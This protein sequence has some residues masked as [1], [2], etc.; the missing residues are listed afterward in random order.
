MMRPKTSHLADSKGRQQPEMTP[1]KKLLIVMAALA[2]L[3]V[4][5]QDEGTVLKSSTTTVGYAS[6]KPDGGLAV[7]QAWEGY[8]IVKRADGNCYRIERTNLRIDDVG[9]G[10]HPRFDETVTAIPCQG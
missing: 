8:K 5:A 2:P 6:V 9:N 1:M 4:S 10:Q 3:A 7:R